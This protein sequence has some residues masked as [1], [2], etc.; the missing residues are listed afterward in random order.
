VN[1]QSCMAGLRLRI[2]TGVIVAFAPLFPM[3]AKK[4]AVVRPFRTPGSFA[5]RAALFLFT[6]VIAFGAVLP[7]EFSSPVDLSVP[8]SGGFLTVARTLAGPGVGGRLLGDRWRLNWEEPSIGTAQR[9]RISYE[10][11]GR[12]VS[13]IA[14]GG[15]SLRF[16]FDSAGRVRRIQA[17]TGACVEYSYRGQNLIEVSRNGAIAV[18]YEI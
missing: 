8:S 2:S 12:P 14:A 7:T 17:S 18:K 16:Q 15:T 3:I 1:K 9:A 5:R 4:S 6:G 13:I 10:I 11:T